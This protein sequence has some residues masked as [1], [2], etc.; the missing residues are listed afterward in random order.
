MLA[1]GVMQVEVVRQP[2]VGI[3]PTG[4]EIVLPTA[5]PGE[6]AIIEFNSTIFSGMLTGWGCLP[7]VYPIIRDELDLIEAALKQA[8]QECDGIVNCGFLGWHRRLFCAGD[9]GCGEVVCMV[10]PSSRASRQFWAFL[11]RAHLPR[12]FR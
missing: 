10:L 1:A 5:E 12:R 7:K 6:G 2:V 9:E 8:L 4:D 11:R 3:I